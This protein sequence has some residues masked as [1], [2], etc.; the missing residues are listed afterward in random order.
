MIRLLP[1]R[2]GA[3]RHWL[4]AALVV[5]GLSAE[6]DLRLQAD[7]QELT[8]AQ[9][10]LTRQLLDEV[11]ALLPPAMLERLDR[12]VTVSW[13][14][15][16]PQQV[17]G[18]AT[19]RDRILLN[20]RWLGALLENPQAANLP[21]RLHASLRQELQATLIHELAHLYDREAVWSVEQQRQIRQCRARLDSSGPVG[22]PAGCRGQAERR[23]TFSDSPR[24]LDLAGWPQRVSSRG[25]REQFNHQHLRSPDSYE[26]HDPQEFVAVNLEYFLLD[27]EY[28][29]RRP[30]LAAYFREHFGWQPEHSRPCQSRLP[31]LNASLDKEHNAL[32]WLE[33]ERI[34][35][36]HYLLAEPDQSWAGRW[37]HSMLRLVICAPGRPAGPDCLLDLQHHLVLSYRAFVDDLQLSSWDGLTGVYPSRLFILPLQRVVDEYTRTELRSLSSVPLD[38]DRQQISQLAQG[39]ATQH[40][41]YDG[42][43]YF[44]GNNCA[45]ETLKL[46]RSGSN[47]PQLQELDSQTPVGLL[48][49]MQAWGLADTS[50]LDDRQRAMRLGYY[51]DSYRDRYQQLFARIRQPL[52]LTSEDF[53]DWLAMDAGQRNPYLDNQDQAVTAALLLLEQ[54]ALRQHVQHIQQDLKQ[55]YLS[56]RDGTA[57]LTEAGQLM[58]TMLEDGS[59]LSRPADLLE[60]GYGLP[61]PQ[62]WAGLDDAAQQR[63]SGLLEISELL[64][65]QLPELL[66]HQ[67]RTELAGIEAN[68]EL[69]GSRLRQLHREAG[70]LLLP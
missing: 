4:G 28:G 70:G 16:L 43:Y 45:V 59:F 11:S 36:V 65:E 8:A 17:M 55:R 18:R 14:Q 61:L 30:A 32:A 19:P 29:C 21:G 5:F 57:A 13:S 23:F 1:T 7:D 41:S 52:Q 33:P 49:L 35:Q 66:N 31:Y 56:G 53:S 60:V 15:R 42:T 39:A 26:L 25:Q 12:T 64:A 24:L 48:Q 67:Q 58:Q 63:Y 54:A 22:L 40:W 34:Y 50:P 62:D 44:V 27:A 9:Q 20:Q 37:G 6:A 51:F 69:L 3:A 10:Q 38:L 47:H 46:L 2:F 68:I